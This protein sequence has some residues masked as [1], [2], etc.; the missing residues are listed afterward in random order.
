M[1][2]RF[3]LILSFLLLASVFPLAAQNGFTV[4]GIVMTEQ[5]E[6]LPG[7]TIQYKNNPSKGAITDVDGNFRMDNVPANTVLVFTYIG[8][9]PQ[10]LVVNGNKTKQKIAL[11]EIV[12]ETDEV[13]IV[14]R[15]TQRKI[16]VVGAVTNVKASDLQVPSSSVTNMLGGRVP[17]IIA[18]TRSGE[19]GNDFSEFWIRGISTFGAGASALVLIDGVEGDLNILDPADIESFTILKDASSTAVYGVRGANGVVLVT[20]KRGKSG[21]LNISVKSNVGLSY[22][23]RNP[24]YVDGYTYAQL[25]N[26]ASVVRGGRPVY[27]NAELNLIETGLDPDL[28]PNVNWRDVMLKDYVWNNQ[29]HISING[30][31]TNARYYMSVGLQHKDAIYKQDKGIKNYDN[32]VGYNKYN[33]RA[34]IDANLTKS[35]IIELGL[36]T[37]IV[38]NSFP[39][40]ANDTKALWQTQANLTPVTVPV[41]YSDGSLPAYGASA[42]QQNPY[43]LLNYTGYKKKNETTSSIRLRLEQDFDQ[44]I[45]GLKAEATMSI[46]NYS[47]LTQSQTKTPALYYAQGRNKD[48]SL[49]LI[50]KVAKTDDKYESTNLSTRKIYLTPVLTITACSIMTIA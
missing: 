5:G 27:S 11:K 19:P 49:N 45:K 33:F 47:A 18:V 6:E 28:Y 13:V 25:A 38:T 2:N 31:G 50:E 43:I 37:E 4:S 1:R 21:K 42:D 34:N 17:G 48:G 8:Y 20:T 35:T 22:S 32:S 14:G 30:G 23:A 16:S 40:Y 3:F 15:G 9:A 7:V 26:E 10:E 41:L 12:N 46:N 29:H 44:W 24:E 36:S 39:G